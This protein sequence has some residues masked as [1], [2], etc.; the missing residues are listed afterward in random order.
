M[1]EGLNKGSFNKFIAMWAK[2]D[3][4]VSR[5]VQEAGAMLT[6]AST[7]S[8][9]CVLDLPGSSFFMMW[10]PLAKTPALTL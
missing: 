7:N 5:R 1:A 8:L 6:G 9:D 4:V 10:L 3:S 2:D